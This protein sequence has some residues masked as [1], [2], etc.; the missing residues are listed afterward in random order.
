[1]SRPFS[2]NDENFSVIGN[3][4]FVHIKYDESAPP[5]T[6]LCEVPPAIYD[7][8][9]FYTNVGA[10]CYPVDGYGAGTAS[11]S[12]IEYENKFYLTNK[13]KLVAYKNRYIYVTFIL[14]DI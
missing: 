1:M 8:L 13:T 3:V 7:R 12:V 6:R 4:L 9:L 5:E 14:K 2:Y 11:Y 10:S